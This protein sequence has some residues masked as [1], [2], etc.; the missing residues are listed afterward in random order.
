MRAARRLDIDLAAAERTRFGYRR[1]GGF[2]AAAKTF[3]FVNT[4]DDQEYNE[5]HDQKIDDRGDKRA[6]L[7][8][9]A[10]DTKHVIVEIGSP[11]KTDNRRDDVL[12][13]GG[14]ETGEGTA[15]QNADGKVEHIAP[16]SEGF[17]FLQ[18]LFHGIFLHFHYHGT[19]SI[20]IHSRTQYNPLFRKTATI[21][22]IRFHS[23]GCWRTMRETDT[24]HY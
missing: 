3:N 6:V 7:D 23:S 22:E 19:V 4:F 1:R 5:S 20:I 12:G 18:K 16:E 9:R 17:E 10:V 14:D 21:K 13:Q 2:L 8:G 24:L 15:D 11:E